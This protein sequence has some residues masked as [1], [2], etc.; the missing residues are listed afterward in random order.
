MIEL[1]DDDPDAVEVLLHW[2]YHGDYN[3]IISGHLAN[4]EPTWRFHLSIALAADK[5]L[6]PGLEKAA[7]F[8]LSEHLRSTKSSTEEAAHM[9]EV[10]HEMD[11]TPSVAAM[12]EQVRKR[13]LT[14]LLKNPRF[15]A[16]LD[17]NSELRWK[18]MEG[19]ASFEA[20]VPKSATLSCDYCGDRF[21]WYPPE[22]FEDLCMGCREYR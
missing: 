14:D 7:V 9:L 11:V 10:V 5:Y 21:A 3:S 16:L 22:K 15:R 8:A 19:L 6:C 13:M 17:R 1:K 18:I 12:A 2:L 20:A 4:R